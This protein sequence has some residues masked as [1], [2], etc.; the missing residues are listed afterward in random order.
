[1]AGRDV[2]IGY[3]PAGFGNATAHLLRLPRDPVTL[4]AV[5]AGGDAREVDLVAVDGRLALFAGVGWDGRVA[6]RYA[7]AGTRGLLG[8]AGAITRSM[9]DLVRRSAVRVEADGKRIHEGPM[10]MLVVGTTPWYGRG[11]L[12]NP[13]AAH[14]AAQLTLRVYGNAAPGF[15]VEV[16]RWL[17]RRPPRS[18]AT[19][20]TAVRVVSITEEPIAVQADGDPLGSRT[21]WQFTIRPHAVRL[22]GRW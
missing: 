13:G 15:A 9:P 21:E 12:V 11:L 6:D 8:W 2:A 22:I 3:I 20:A 16:L 7:T 4:A 5:L 18:H 10:E 1:M 14:D 17:V 19:T